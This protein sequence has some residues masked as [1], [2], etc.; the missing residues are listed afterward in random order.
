MSILGAVTGTAIYLRL[1][2]DR[3]GRE[4]GVERQ[5]RECQALADRHGLTAGQPYVDNDKGASTRSKKRRPDYERLIRD[6]E[7]GKVRT[8]VAYSLSRLTR[9][10][11]EGEAIIDLAERR[12]LMVHTV[13]SG[14]PNLRTADGRMIYR[15]V[16]AI[17]CAESERI[18][19]RITLEA[20]QRAEMGRNMGGPRRFGRSMDG[21][22]LVTEEAEA[23]A[24]AY[25]HVAAGGT[26][27]AVVKE[28]KRRGLTGARGGTLT[29]QQVRSS[30]M[31]ACNGGLA[32][33]K[34]VIIGSSQLPAI[35]DEDLWREVNE[36]LLDPARIPKRGR[37]GQAL[38]TGVLKCGVCT[39][40]MYARTRTK[41]QARRVYYCHHN[42]CVDRD[43]R[44]VEE[45]ITELVLA[46]IEKHHDHLS[47][48]AATVINPAKDE[49]AR[50]TDRIKR[51]QRLVIAEEMD[52]EDAAPILGP[53]RAALKAAE[54]QVVVQAHR[55]ATAALVASGDVRAA[56]LNLDVPGRNAIVKEV[57]V[58][59]EVLRT[60]IGRRT[61]DPNTLVPEWQS[62]GP[63]QG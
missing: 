26:L 34:G 13:A 23:L 45:A 25:R 38:L 9:R 44:K 63:Q 47:K 14:D 57:L 4:L 18:S 59:V 37:P 3:E 52:P 20:R 55:P 1:S 62:L 36:I 51:V 24:W 29:S 48:P 50:L 61:L 5:L 6:I 58:K 19:E 21:T 31:V 27:Y 17:D 15:M 10:P 41:Q 28:W 30:L 46:Y 8:V 11:R 56:W 42:G 2:E 7:A 32:A 22:Q 12:G 54:A 60:T 43:R 39:G 40:P 35:V 33:Y 16:V 53:L 49:V